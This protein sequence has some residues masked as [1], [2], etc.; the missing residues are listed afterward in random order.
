[1]PTAPA[2]EFRFARMMAPLS[3]TG[4]TMRHRPGQGGR[5][6]RFVAL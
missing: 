6:R 1:V 3:G 4:M 5:R 2:A